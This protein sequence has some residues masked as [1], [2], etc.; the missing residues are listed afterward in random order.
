M[1]QPKLTPSSDA[2]WKEYYHRKLCEEE[3]QLKAIAAMLPHFLRLGMEGKTSDLVMLAR[4]AANALKYPR[5]R[6]PLL[7]ELAK[8]P[9][10]CGSVL[11]KEPTHD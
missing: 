8:C 4:R 1:D 7:D 11:R 5:D 9:D 10:A 3:R 2:D 6:Q